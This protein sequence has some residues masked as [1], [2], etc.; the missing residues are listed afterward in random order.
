[1]KVLILLLTVALLG[2]NGC[3]G[4]PTP[5]LRVGADV[6]PGYEPLYLARDLGYFQDKPI[7]PVEFTSATQVIR[8]YQNDAID[9][10]CLT[11]DEA[12]LLAS[13]GADFRIV[14]TADF[15]N[16][17]DVIIGAPG[18]QFMHDLRGRR[19]GVE[20]TALGAFFL[21][22]ALQE[23]GMQ[24]GDVRVVPMQAQ[25]H[26]QAFLKGD[27]DAVVTFEPVRSKLLARGAHILF[28]S[29]RIPSEIVD[30]VLVRAD[31]LKQHPQAVAD[32]VRG[33]Q[34]AQDYLARSSDDA[35]ARMAR[36]EA[37]T[38]TEMR[39]ALRGV[40]LPSREEN[41]Q[42]LSGR[43]PALKPV[44]QRLAK[45]MLQTKLLQSPAPVDK[46]IEP[47]DLQMTPQ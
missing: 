12:L 33:W 41:F 15:S 28:D 31:Y 16:G 18:T 39:E 34:Q 36:R 21:T 26:E 23:S 37:A 19:V 11:L 20:D 29:S 30:V 22:R 44:L 2:L 4:E 42:L 47:H 17:A 46:L 13:Q 9:A 27:V 32:L 24:T 1:M 6:W 8:A 14:L 7:H 43:E 35:L 45:F 40:H 25:D 38:V 10:V 3:T 5:V